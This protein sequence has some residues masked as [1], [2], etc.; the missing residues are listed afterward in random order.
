MSGRHR[1]TTALCALL[2]LVVAAVP[3]AAQSPFALTNIGADVRSTDARIDGRGGWGLAESDT[4]TPSFHNLAGLTGLQAM[5]IVVSGY[6]ERTSSK[7]AYGNRT[8]H[9]VRTPTLRAAAPFRQ[10]RLVLSAGFRS[11]RGTQYETARARTFLLPDPEDPLGPDAA[12]EGTES[13]VR[14]GTQ[15]EVPLGLSWRL[16]DRVAVGASLNIVGGVIRENIA[17]VFDEPATSDGTNFF[18]TS[19]ETREEEIDGLSTTWSV[20]IDPTPR[21]SVGA[22]YTP[23]HDW[24]VARKL[25]MTGLPGSVTDESVLSIPETWGVGAAYRLGDR[26]R[27]GA[28]YE[29]QPFTA[30]AGRDDWA[31]VMVDAWRMGVGV[32]RTEAFARRGGRNN[33][34]LRLG[35]S[36]QRW[37]YLVQGDEVIERRVS[38]GTGFAFRERSGHLDLALSYAWTGELG[39]NGGRDRTWRFTVSVAGLEKWW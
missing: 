35:F 38:A 39:T 27:V 9:R 1:N 16:H 18:L 36:M 25:D 5:A 21:L 8:T 37:P 4:L 31:A 24:D 6:G 29:A 14:E 19:S 15:F 28:E 2:C 32:E 20:L 22:T 26:W 7:D 3:A 34:P 23:A 12:F 11:L 30:F 13:L 17:L 10:G 33:L